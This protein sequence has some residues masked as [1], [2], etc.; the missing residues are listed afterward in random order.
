MVTSKR[1][2]YESYREK[3]K[4]LA[5]DGVMTTEERDTIL[6]FLDAKD[7]ESS[8]VPHDDTKADGTI[9]RY[10]YS[11]KRIVELSDFELSDTTEMEI[12]RLME[13]IRQGRIDGVKEGG[14]SKG[15]VR[16]HQTALRKYY[17][18]HDDLGIDKDDIIV[19]KND[20]SPV[21][22]RDVF[23]KEDIQALREAATHPRDAALVDLL[24]YTGQRISAI[25]NLRLKDMKPEDGIFYLNTENGDM[26]G[27]DGKRPLLLAE[28]SV[29]E[30]K[31]KHPCDDPEAHFIT[32]W[33][34]TTNQDYSHG[35]RLD[36]SSIL[37]VLRTIGKR[38]D[39]DKP[40]NPHSFRHSFV[41]IAKRNYEMDNDTIKR[42][43]G[44]DESSTV[45][46]TTYAHIT[47]DDVIDKAERAAGIKDEEPES[48]LTP[49]VCDNCQE[50]IP[51]DDAKACPSCGIVFTPDAKAVEDS[52]EETLWE[53]KGEAETEVE[54]NA[55][56]VMK[57]LL[58]ENPEIVAQAVMEGSDVDLDSLTETDSS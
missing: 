21:D 14:L 38:A 2:R 24:L 33:Q 11:M 23:D 18:Y 40:V 13:D 54:E 52:V 36:N 28:K 30:W 42:L 41:T 50:P 32:H 44:H 5:D 43:I 3:I 49:D 9:S 22:E 31:R 4:G 29:R 35:D 16:N 47:D 15:S 57:Q 1:Q 37:R 53:A 7:P 25:L 46:E 26:K 56:N 27:A 58:D 10:A 34:D 8:L 55:V 19:F 12:N 6:E 17:E 39:V 48:P 20:H 45:M 51:I